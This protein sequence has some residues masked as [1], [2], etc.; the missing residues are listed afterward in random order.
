VRTLVLG[1][2][3]QIGRRILSLCLAQPD[4]HVGAVVTAPLHLGHPRLRAVTLDPFSPRTSLAGL[5]R[6]VDAC[7]ICELGESPHALAGAALELLVQDAPDA[8][9]VVLCGPEQGQ[10]PELA[11]RMGLARVHALTP[12]NLAAPD[13]VAAQ[14]LAP[15]RPA[16]RRVPGWIS[17]P[18]D[19]AAAMLRCARDPDAPRALDGRGIVELLRPGTT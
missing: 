13:S 16:L 5:T 11:E 7:L 18:E 10:I 12:A 4:V 17:E 14:I 2:D 3:G 9:L 6:G 1:A 19:V 15:L 8:A